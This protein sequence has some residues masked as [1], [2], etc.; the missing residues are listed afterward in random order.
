MPRSRA[1]RAEALILRRADFGEADR[2]VTLLTRGH[3]KVRAIARGARRPTS[4]HSG[5]LEL[6][7][8]AQLLLRCGRDLDTISQSE[9]LH[10]FRKVRED[11]EATSHAYYLAE[12]TD[13]LVQPS[14]GAGR[15][16]GLVLTAFQA[17]EAGA[18]P[19][20][21]AAH[22]LLHL[23]DAL[24]YRPELVVCLACGRSVQPGVNF[25]SVGQGGTLCP[26]CGP[27][28]AGAQPIGVGP[29]KVM[30]YLQR[31]EPIGTAGLSLTTALVEQVDRSV[32]GFAEYQIDRSLRAPEFINRLRE[33]GDQAAYNW[34]RPSPERSNSWPRR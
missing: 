25:L 8:H 18:N 16:F 14:D 24:G 31:T 11:L 9:L 13:A 10:P 22:F 34:D 20:L 4:R 3:G 23:L 19:P 1:Y 7:G 5:N 30:R 12:V 21:L 6:F 28:Q 15:P 27:K 2:L 17:L 26:E 32:R 29:L 33:L